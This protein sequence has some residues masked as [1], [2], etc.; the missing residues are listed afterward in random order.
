MRPRL[1]LLHSRLAKNAAGDDGASAVEYALIVVS[2]AA[3]IVLIVVSL[4]LVVNKSLNNSCDHISQTLNA[5][6][7]KCVTGP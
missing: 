7:N 3:V 4:G 2:I 1:R 6:S 5:D